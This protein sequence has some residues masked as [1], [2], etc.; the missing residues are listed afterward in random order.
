[1][2]RNLF[3]TTFATDLTPANY[4]NLVAFGISCRSSLQCYFDVN[5]S[6][7]LLRLCFDVCGRSRSVLGL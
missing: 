4:I 5:S 3:L 2:T 7:P 6:D 1:M